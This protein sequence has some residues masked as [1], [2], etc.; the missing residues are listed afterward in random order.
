MTHYGWFVVKHKQTKATLSIIMEYQENSN[1]SMDLTLK[2]L[3]TRTLSVIKNDG[4]ILANI[5]NEETGQ[6]MTL[7]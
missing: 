2:L 5:T 7:G 6:G 4:S 1:D 3:S